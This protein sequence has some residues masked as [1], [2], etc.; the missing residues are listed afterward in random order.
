M[1]KRMKRN[2][3]GNRKT[4]RPS[5]PSRSG[6]TVSA[7]GKNIST[8]LFR[9][10]DT[11]TLSSGSGGDI[12]QLIS[13]SYTQFAEAKALEG[14]FTEV[15]LKAFSVSITPARIYAK[16]DSDE[17]NLSM[18]WMAMGT[19]PAT[20]V[21]ALTTGD[22]ILA[23]SDSREFFLR[24]RIRPFVFNSSIL[25]GG[26]EYTP[27]ASETSYAFAGCPG[28]IHIGNMLSGSEAASTDLMYVIITGVYQFTGRT[29]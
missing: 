25:Q 26:Y 9:L 11:L 16:T 12:K 5:G 2:K 20:T 28:T 27:F 17:K 14:L 15:R 22:Q 23:Q 7:M 13:R 18:G 10:R 19:T 29:A 8:G 3:K 24:G 1:S 4:S 21:T 6:Q